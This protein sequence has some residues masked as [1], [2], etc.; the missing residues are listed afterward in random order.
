MSAKRF[1]GFVLAL[2]LV[3]VCLVAPIS[4]FAQAPQQTAK[5]PAVWSASELETRLAAIEKTLDAKR[6]EYG[7]P[8]VSLVI[9]KDDQII[10]LMGLG[11][12]DLEKKV[13]VTADT[14]FAI[15]SSTKAFTALTVLM[16]AD[17]GKLSLDDSPKKYLPYFKLY[18]PEADAKITIRDLLSHSSGLNRTD[19]GFAVGT[20]NREEVIRV[21]GLAQ[22]TSK[23]REK[24][25]YQNVMFTAAGEVAGRAQGMSWEE[26]VRKRIFKPLGMKNTDLSVK[27]MEKSRDFSYGYIYNTDTKKNTRVPMREI[28][29]AAPAGAINSTAREMAAWLR[30][31]LGGGVFD[32]KRLVS[33]KGYSEFTSKQMTIGGKVSY[34]LGWFLRDWNGHKVLEHGGNIDGFN[35][36]VALMP[37]QNLGFVLLTNISASPLGNDA[38]KTIWSNLVGEP[39]NPSLPD[40][41]VT[42]LDKSMVVGTYKLAEANMNIDVSI[43]DS[44]LEMTVPG[45]P[46]YTLE[47]TGGNRYKLIYPG[48]EGFYATFRLVKDKP[49]VIEMY[50]EQPQGN[51]VLPRLGASEKPSVPATTGNYDGPH[52]ELIGTYM[53]EG[54]VVSI[55]VAA[56][57]GKVQLI[58]PGQQPYTL[59][60]KAIDEYALSPLPESQYKVNVKRDTAGNV[61]ALVTTQPEGAFTFVRNAS[62]SAPM[63]ADELMAKVIEASG[64]ERLRKHTSMTTRFALNFIHQGMLGEGTILARAPNMQSTDTTII[65]LGKRVGSIFEYFDGANGGQ[66]TSF[67]PPETY[68]GKQ[69]AGARINADF[70]GLLNWKMLFKTVE[71]KRTAKVGE[72]ETYVVVLTPAEGNPITAYVSTKSFLLMRRDTL[73]SPSDSSGIELPVS[74]IYSNYKPVDGLMLPFKT[75]TNSPGQGDIIVDIKDVKFDAEIPDTAFRPKLKK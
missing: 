19:L 58:V 7:I 36:E 60:E 2:T 54:G 43:V 10:Y 52:K 73:Y 12:K 74:E 51:F 16:S 15:G 23:F 27:E 56:K 57:D 33:E 53:I 39:K 35:A 38:M 41:A 66:D 20:L 30:F 62:F 11:F 28:P 48:L 64:G 22:P 14:L 5:A 63:S 75:V 32:G 8:G 65:A 61:T 31:M 26:L 37:D 9:V 70:Y 67:S 50:L 72:E 1:L 34:G 17:D 6:Q 21:A 49:N 55:E 42:E 69:L 68:T 29:A 25:Q 3:I 4:V 24:F 13:P 40:L 59:A 47:N 45:Q 44:K 71:I 18:D 46:K